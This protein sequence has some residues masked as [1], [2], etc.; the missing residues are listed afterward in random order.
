MKNLSWFLLL[1]LLIPGEL[2]FSQIQIG[3]KE[4]SLTGYFMS[5]S[6]EGSDESWETLNLSLGFGYFVS[7]GFEIEPEIIFSSYEEEKSGWIFSGNVAYN[8][9]TGGDGKGPVPFIL[10]G[11]GYSNTFLLLPRIPYE[12][13]DE[14]NWTVF[15]AGA[16]LKIFISSP[17]C[18]RIEYRFQKFDG[19]Y[20]FT[21][22]LFLFGISAFIK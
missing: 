13:D 11:I 15:N 20:D 14:E 10:A 4:L 19:E 5:R 18:L 6:Y 21:H 1:L 12:G 8:F 22:H 9:Q 16:G 3:S 17:A 7:Q 2:A